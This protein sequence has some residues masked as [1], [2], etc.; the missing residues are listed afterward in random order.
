VQLD[1]DALKQ[2]LFNAIDN[3]LKYGR[4]GDGSSCCSCAR[5]RR[6]MRACARC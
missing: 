5:T 6:S 4:G 2:M 3:A 1:I